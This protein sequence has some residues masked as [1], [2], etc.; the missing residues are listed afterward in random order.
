VS[1]P[2]SRLVRRGRP[3]KRWCYAGV[4]GPELMWCAG[5]VH[6]AG[7]PQ[8]FWAAWDRTTLVER[9]RVLTTR[10]VEV[11]PAR[12]RVDGVASL[13]LVAAGA[14]I[15]V[16]SPHGRATVWTRK[17][18]VHAT[19]TVTVDGRTFGV[20]SHGLVDETAGHHARHTAWSWSAGVGTATDGRAVVWNLVDGVHDA[21]QGSERTV[22]VDG[23]PGEAGPATFADDLSAVTV[24]S[25]E[26]LVFTAEAVRRRHDRLVVIDSDY[27]QPFG[28][29]AGTL[30][31]GVTLAE[32]F[33]VM[34]H[35]RARW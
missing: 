32:G 31:G 2:P 19:G 28:V 5:V 7:I 15:D 16:T 33:G 17:T 22:W 6:V 23:T 12:V 9:T 21:A 30:P 18:P 13:D 25:G 27:V 3:L 20:D 11:S 34:E 1:P 10:G 8:T 14:P 35:H 26:R 24:A 4:F 29:F